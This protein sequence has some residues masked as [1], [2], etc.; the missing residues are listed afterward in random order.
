MDKN[1]L[2]FTDKA[3]DYAKFRPSYPDAAV[4]W[5]KSKIFAECVV[6]IGAGTGIFTQVLLKYFTNVSAIEPNA[7]MREKFK[8]FLPDI[9]CLAASGEAT[10]LADNSVDLITVAQAFH[11][12]DAEKFKKRGNAYFETVRQNGDRLEYDLA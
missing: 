9:L 3:D 6:D 12:L 5:L 10:G 2:L 8:N 1:T 7:Q 11:W 4:R